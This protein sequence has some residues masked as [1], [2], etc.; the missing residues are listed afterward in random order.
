M[1]KALQM[2][3]AVAGM[4]KDDRHRTSALLYEHGETNLKLHS[5]LFSFI[6]TVQEEVHRFAVDYHRKL[7]GKKLSRSI[8]DG[9][10]GV[11]EKR[12]LSLL[13]YFGS[14]DAIKAASVEDIASV[15]SLN[16]MV[17]EKV[18]RYLSGEQNEDV[19]GSHKENK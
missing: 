2:D 3:I 17:A 1:L 18:H 7:R 13:S 19:S 10:E 6:G 14:V 4:V 11:G 5:D 15:P 9:I 12:K 8:L 16:R